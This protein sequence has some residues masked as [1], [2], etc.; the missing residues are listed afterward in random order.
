MQSKPAVTSMSEF[1]H[2]ERGFVRHWICA[3]PTT[4]PTAPSNTVRQGVILSTPRALPTSVTAGGPG[5]DGKRWL[6]HSPGSNWFVDRGGFYH[7]P[8]RLGLWAAADFVSNRAFDLGFRVWTPNTLDLWCGSTHRLRYEP[9][10][11]GIT[12]PSPTTTAASRA[13]T[14]PHPSAGA[15]LPPHLISVRS[16]NH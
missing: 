11:P 6:Y 9:P 14:H 16:R 8:Q 5:P 3:G 12:S 4:T 7:S 2:D 15:G 10:S 13:D 1:T